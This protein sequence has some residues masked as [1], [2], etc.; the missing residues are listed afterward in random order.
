MENGHT[1]APSALAFPSVII[2]VPLQQLKRLLIPA[3]TSG[4]CYLQSSPPS[5]EGPDSP[6]ALSPGRRAAAS[7]G[8]DGWGWQ[9]A[10]RREGEPARHKAA[11]KDREIGR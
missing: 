8:K 2:Q 10:G 3:R 7:R 1:A 6:S 4:C 11:G 9:G 5:A